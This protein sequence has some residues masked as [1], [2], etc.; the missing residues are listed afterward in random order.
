MVGERGSVVAFDL[1]GIHSKMWCNH[2][3]TVLSSERSL[4][5]AEETLVIESL[6]RWIGRWQPDAAAR[7]VVISAAARTTASSRPGTRSAFWNFD[8]VVAC[9]AA[10]A[11]RSPTKMMP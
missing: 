6:K 5:D 1:G 11:C 10:D 3:E 2:R 7:L 9:P 8:S 4:S